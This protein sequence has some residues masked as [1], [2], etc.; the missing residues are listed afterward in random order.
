MRQLANS[1]IIVVL[2]LLSL[3]Q[4]A[5]SADLLSM[6]AKTYYQ[7]AY[8]DYQNGD[9][10]SAVKSYQKAMLL[11]ANYQKDSLNNIG[12]IF[13]R[14]GFFEKAEQ[15]F[16]AALQADPDYLPAKINLGLLYE[17]NGLGLQANRWWVDCFA[18]AKMKPEIFAEAD[19]TSADYFLK[20]GQESLEKEEYES[21]RQ[22]FLQALKEEPNFKPAQTNIALSYEKENDELNAL[23]WW[24]KVFDI[25]KLKARD[26]VRV[27]VTEDVWLAKQGLVAAQN[28]EFDS[29]RQFFTRALEINPNYKPA[30]I[31]LALSCEKL[32]L[33]DEANKWWVKAFDLN[34][35]HS[36]EYIFSTEGLELPKNK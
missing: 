15:S 34:T 11:D 10:E 8:Q 31:D 19:L 32:E 26:F 3:S 23:R 28:Q 9:N 33:Q 22:F 36:N 27:N 20:L 16:R 14:M 17:K 1:I 6:D 18:V 24:A 2:L 25:E 21:A 12:V 5:F 30:Q 7:K 35:K 13:G 4:S 29:A